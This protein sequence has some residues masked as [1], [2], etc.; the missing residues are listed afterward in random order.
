MTG[1]KTELSFHHLTDEQKNAFMIDIPLLIEVLKSGKLL[2]GI[3]S[4]VNG[5]NGNMNLNVINTSLWLFIMNILTMKEIHT[6]MIA[7]ET[8]AKTQKIESLPLNLSFINKTLIPLNKQLPL[9]L[10]M[11]WCKKCCK[12]LQ[13]YSQKVVNTDLKNEVSTDNLKTK[14]KIHT[15]EEL[16]MKNADEYKNMYIYPHEYLCLV[17]NS[18]D[19]LKVFGRQ[20]KLQLISS[21]TQI[22]DSMLKAQ[23]LQNAI[24]QQKREDEAREKGELLKKK[25]VKIRNWFIYDIS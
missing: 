15:E 5:R 10:F 3:P 6:I 7:F 21:K 1:E 11:Y 24:E 14:Y 19:R 12:F 18:F 9:S 23:M 20:K 4:Y 17:C 2:S 13:C 16:I 22:T 25:P 8:M